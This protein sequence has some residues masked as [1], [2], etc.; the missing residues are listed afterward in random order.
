MAGKRAFETGLALTQKKEKRRAGDGGTYMVIANDAPEFDV[1]LNYAVHMAHI[2][3][4]HVALARII[5]PSDFVGWGQIE[6]AAKNEAR[7]KAEIE[8]QSI[9]TRVSNET[10]V[11][12]SLTLREG[13]LHDEIIR[14]AN[15][16]KSLSG[17]V[18]ATS[19]TPGRG[20]PLIAYFTAK[21]LAKLSVPIIIVPGHLDAVTVKKLL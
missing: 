13:N 6:Q 17:I 21:G 9:A 11:T 1:A 2:H 16:N 12:P 5:E 20:D 4:G 3:Q 15:S 8:L 7:A 10:G 19:V 18:L 14:I